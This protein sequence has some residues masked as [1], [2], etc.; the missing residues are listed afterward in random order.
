MLEEEWQRRIRTLEL[1]Q[2]CGTQSTKEL[3]LRVVKPP[4]PLGWAGGEAQK[5]Q[6]PEL[7]Q[8]HFVEQ[9]Q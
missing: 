7:P 8:I 1:K 4:P 3:V 5:E 6:R 2:P 9:K